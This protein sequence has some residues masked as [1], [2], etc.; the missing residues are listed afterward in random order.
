QNLG[1]E[2]VEAAVLSSLNRDAEKLAYALLAD[3]AFAA[4]PAGR[5]LLVELARQIG[6][7]GEQRELG[8]LANDLVAARQTNETLANEL[9]VS[10]MK[11]AGANAPAALREMNAQAA[12][13]APLIE[14]LV[15]QA[16]E[17]AAKGEGDPAARVAAIQQLGMGKFTA[18][19]P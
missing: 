10:V 2:Y 4:S 17:L 1:N 16:I 13:I 5:K 15:T 11:G 18:V 8:S 6:A 12:E 3:E 7:R 14:R 19:A 9:L